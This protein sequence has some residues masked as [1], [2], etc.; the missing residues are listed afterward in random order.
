[1]TE[2]ACLS[3]WTAVVVD[4]DEVEAND[5]RARAEDHRRL[6]SED[7]VNSSFEVICWNGVQLF[8]DVIIGVGFTSGIGDGLDGLLIDSSLQKRLSNNPGVE[9][10]GFDSGN[11]YL[12]EES[13]RLSKSEAVRTASGW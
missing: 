1:V 7:V 2:F 10:C 8:E 12:R 9:G 13:F 11:R 4:I 6:L 5:P 3:V